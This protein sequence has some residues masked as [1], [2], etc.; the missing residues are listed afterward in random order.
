M[1]LPLTAFF[2]SS[3]FVNLKVPLRGGCTEAAEIHEK[4]KRIDNMK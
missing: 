1:L 3:R 2:V 4:R